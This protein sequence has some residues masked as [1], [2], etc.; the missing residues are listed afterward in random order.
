MLLTR[1]RSSTRWRLAACLLALL[2]LM[3]LGAPSSAGATPETVRVLLEYGAEQTGRPGSGPAV[4]ERGVNGL[5]GSVDRTFPDRQ[6]ISVSLPAPALAA[7][8]KLPGVAAVHPVFDLVPLL[9]RSVPLVRAPELLVS[10][11]PATGVGQAIAIIDTG[12]DA[13]HPVFSGAEGGSRVVAEA[14]FAV[15]SDCPNGEPS[16]IGPGAGAPLVFRGEVDNHGTH[17]AGI[18]AAG[19]RASSPQRGIAPDSELVAVRIF[20]DDGDPSSTVPSGSSA[21]LLAALEWLLQ[22][23]SDHAVSAV[24]L[25]FGFG[26][27]TGS[28]D[29][30]LGSQPIIDAIDELAERGVVTVA[31]AGNSGS[32]SEMSWPACLSSVVSVA[33]TTSDDRLASY[34]NVSATTDLGAPGSGILSAAVGGFGTMSGSSMAAPHVAGAVSLLRQLRPDARTDQIVASLRTSRAVIAD[35]RSGASRTGL[36]FLDLRTAGHG[37][38]RE[39]VAL[40]PRRIL[41]TR[42]SV[43]EF[44][45]RVGQ[46]QTRSV[47]VLG[48]GGV[49]A[50]GVEAVVVN[51]NARSAS[52]STYLTVWPSGFVRRD[53]ATLHAS[54]GLDAGNEVV[55]KVGDDGRVN[56]FNRWGNVHVTV[57]VV[58]YVPAP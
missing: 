36:P 56:V 31:A 3:W 53:L 21:D 1:C 37:L 7:V 39:V 54:P 58:G 47:K 26:S 57:D 51:V 48:V 29:G 55:V 15:T 44:Q 42:N 6:L 18:A 25:S 30:L 38:S 41:D 23:E 4:V 16:Q 50:S 35:H 19:V 5:G 28:C 8:S 9:D 43:G 52:R 27:F 49:P 32:R 45:G 34:T 14:C 17:V 22:I 40:R 24:N 13:D 46:R 10:G 20:G 2:S 12:I 11:A 33:A